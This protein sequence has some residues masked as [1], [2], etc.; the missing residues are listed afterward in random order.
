MDVGNCGGAS[1]CDLGLAGCIR[2]EQARAGDGCQRPLVPRIVEAILPRRCTDNA[3]Y[4]H[5]FPPVCLLL[6]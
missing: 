1:L 5:T 2:A 6:A 4:L 3:R